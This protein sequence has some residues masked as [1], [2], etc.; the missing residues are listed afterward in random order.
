MN[1]EV[2]ICVV[3]RFLS[4]MIFHVILYTGLLASARQ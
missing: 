3:L 1:V 4:V 2:T